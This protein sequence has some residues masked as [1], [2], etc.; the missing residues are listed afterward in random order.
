MLNQSSKST[1]VLIFALCFPVALACIDVMAVSVALNNIIHDFVTTISRV[2]WLLTSYIIGTA[3]F[4]VTIGR[5]ADK[6]GRRKLLLCGVALF[7]VSSLAAG[8]SPTMLLLIVSRFVQGV[9][10]AMLM[11]TVVS[12]IMHSISLA[13]RPQAVAHWGMSLGLGMALG[14]LFGGFILHFF[15]W[16]FIF[17][18]NIP[19]CIFVYALINCFVPESKNDMPFK[20][21]WLE[22]VIFTVLLA[23]VVLLLSEG[24]LWGW[25]SLSSLLIEIAVVLCLVLFVFL[26]KNQQDSIIDFSLF[27]VKNY[28]AATLCGF[29]SYFCMYAWLFVY[30]IYLQNHLKMSP[31]HAGFLVASYSLGFA[32]SSRYVAKAIRMLGGKMTMQLGFV[33]AVMALCL[34][35]IFS[36]AS[37]IS[38]LAILFYLFGIGITFINAPSITLATE[39]VSTQK[40]GSASGVL[41]TIRWLGGVLGVAIISILYQLFA[42][43][44]GLQISC[45]ALSAVA[46]AGLILCSVKIETKDVG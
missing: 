43:P 40:S 11:T 16:R 1:S 39:F 33:A 30:N 21:N 26:A 45:M 20:I 12:I 34:M 37:T 38:E 17:L 19:L 25:A 3:A 46:I 2:Q 31:L 18:I 23:L 13:E 22:T 29:A 10:S 7:G 14:P 15:T 41:F 6:Y 8:L 44:Y 32:M 24:S 5:L 9:A 42:Q 4:L 35:A 27:R 28:L 36:H